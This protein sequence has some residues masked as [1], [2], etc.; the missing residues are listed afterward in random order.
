M[1]REIDIRKQP[2]LSFGR[3]VQMTLHGI[4]FRLFR[5]L[6][7]VMVIVVAVA[8]LMNIAAEGIIKKAVARQAEGRVSSQRLALHWASRLAGAPAT[9]EVLRQAA[10][11]KPSSLGSKELARFAGLEETDMDRF[12]S[13]CQQ[14]V[15]VLDFVDTLD[16]S[17]SRRLFHRHMGV[18]IFSALSEPEAWNRFRDGLTSLPSLRFPLALPEFSTFVRGWPEVASRI[19]RLQASRAAASARVAVACGERTLMQALTDARG[20]FGAQIRAE[21][22]A[23]PADVA[24]KVADL[25]AL[26]VDQE[27]LQ[28]AIAD[29]VI[30]KQVAAYLDVMP[31]EVNAVS[32]WGVLGK[33]RSVA[34]FAARLKERGHSASSLGVERMMAVAREQALRATLARA[35]RWSAT[36]SGGVFG[37]GERM[38]WLLLVSMVVCVVGIC[39]AMLMAV[40]ERFR[41]IATFK[42]LGALDGTIMVMFVMESSLFGLIGGVVGALLGGLIGLGRSAAS[43]GTAIID[44][45]PLVELGA[46][47]L[48][49]VVL[50]MFL[51]AA[52]AVYPSWKAARLAPM[53]AMRIEQ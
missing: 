45:L 39:N 24:D 12:R 11:T 43:L 16:Y 14:A 29:P 3:M 37:L 41:E 46:V 36:V 38:G 9:E 10:A 34:W 15:Q 19:E 52:A 47:A 17:Q 26:A 18:D 48:A 21:G 5:S 4:R 42:C 30:R 27:Q 25:A 44:A 6:V 1:V 51:A 32:L 23:F 8:F 20:D 40:T 49:A 50:G 22:F 53:E 33:S 13:T 7:T 28:D 31:G 35:S 2:R